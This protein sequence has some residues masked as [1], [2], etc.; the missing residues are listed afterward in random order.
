MNFHALLRVDSARREA[1]QYKM[2]EN[3]VAR[4]IDIVQNNRNFILDKWILEEKE[5][6]PRLRI[7]IG[8]DLG[9]C[10][11]INAVINN[12]LEKETE[13]V[14][15]T[16]G[17]KLRNRDRV[18]LSLNRDDL[19]EDYYKIYELISNGVRKRLYSGIDICYNHYHNT[20]NIEPRVKTI[21]P[22]ELEKDEVES[23][24]EDFSVEGGR[25]DELMEDLVITY[26]SYEIK[27]ATVNAFAAEN[28]LRQNAT[29][30]SLKK[31]E[32]IEVEQKFEERKEIN[33]LGVQ[34]V[35]D[36]YVKSKRKQL[37]K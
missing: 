10:G 34:K 33:K 17:K 26:L 18:E 32:E 20:T 1:D 24:S 16:I 27:I 36:S 4:M 37:A 12:E 25:V 22:I 19:E 7:Y 11:S 13:N 9:F 15:I 31:I 23:Y 5:G 2:L 3:E 8:S 21:F 30:E 14:I 28:I 6:A 35:I 29:N